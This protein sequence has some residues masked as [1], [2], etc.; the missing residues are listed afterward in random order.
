MLISNLLGKLHAGD[1][2]HKL[3]TKL[4]LLSQ[5]MRLLSQLQSITTLDG[6]TENARPEKDGPSKSRGVKMQDLKMADQVAW[7]ENDRP[8]KSCS[9]EMQDMKLQ[10]LK[11]QDLKLQDLKLQDLKLQDLKMM[12]QIA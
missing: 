6:L 11:M 10:D 4:P 8:S 2:S 9:V 1:I 3:S 5:D 7:H 12:D